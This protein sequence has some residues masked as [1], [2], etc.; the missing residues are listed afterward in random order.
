MRSATFPHPSEGAALHASIFGNTFTLNRLLALAIDYWVLQLLLLRAPSFAK[1]SAGR[2]PPSLIRGKE[3]QTRVDIQRYVRAQAIP[4][5]GDYLLSTATIASDWP[6]RATFLAAL[7]NYRIQNNIHPPVEFHSVVG[8]VAINGVV[9]SPIFD[10]DLILGYG[11]AYQQILHGGAAHFGK[12][13]VV[14]PAADRIGVTDEVNV[15]LVEKVRNRVKPVEKLTG[16]VF[17]D[18][19]TSPAE[20]N[21]LPDLIIL[22]L[23]N[24][25][26]RM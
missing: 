14:F 21:T 12:P 17:A 6:F 16:L 20:I 10:G 7:K 11:F 19:I 18:I 5:V 9:Q 22:L 25:Q 24:D 15:V 3:P 2:R 1:A 23:R 13:L 8:V 26:K 4:G